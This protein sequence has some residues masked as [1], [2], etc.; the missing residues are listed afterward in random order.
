M[1]DMRE[2]ELDPK[3]TALV[4]IDLQH[5]IVNRTT[6]PYPSH[7]VVKKGASLAKK[8]R[9]QG[10][11]VVFVRVDLANLLKISADKS[12]RGAGELPPNA[13]DLVPVAVVQRD[14]V[15]I[16]KRQWGAFFGTDLEVQLRGRGVSTI[17]LG[18]IATNYGVE[19]TARAAA[20]LGFRLVVVEDATTSLNADAHKFSFENIF[21]LIGHVRT[22]GQVLAAFQ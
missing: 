2:L 8:F 17:V 9:E 6:A 5:G 12:M 14:A 16:S 20:G 19:S 4:L 22:T 7:E 21:P 13:S 18:G 11:V 3:T 1:T 15:I 10:A